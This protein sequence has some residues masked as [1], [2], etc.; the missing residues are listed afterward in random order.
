ME[1]APLLLNVLVRVAEDDLVAPEVGHILDTPDLTG[2]QRVED[3]RD[4]HPNGPGSAA[5]QTPGQ[6]VAPILQA[7]GGLEYAIARRYCYPLI[8]VHDP[9]DGLARYTS[10]SGHIVDRGE[11]RALRHNVTHNYSSSLQ[12]G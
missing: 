3:V 11:R 4:Q 8:P 6:G 1:Q 9:R 7:A 10:P 12:N 5:P 2:I